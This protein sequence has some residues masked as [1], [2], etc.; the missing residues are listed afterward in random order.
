MYSCSE[1]CWRSWGPPQVCGRLA[2]YMLALS[3][4]TIT[5]RCFLPPCVLNLLLS[6]TFLSQCQQCTNISSSSSS[7][8]PPPK[9][10][11]PCKHFPTHPGPF[12]LDNQYRQWWV[13]WTQIKVKP[14][15]QQIY[16]NHVLFFWFFFVTHML[17]YFLIFVLQVGKVH[18]CD[19]SQGAH[20]NRL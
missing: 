1:M 19:R 14:T 5:I 9:Y 13:I 15:T 7:P 3:Y 12:Y 16:Y 2:N 8:L 20:Q 11:S 4:Y 17:I 6:C 10:T 18:V